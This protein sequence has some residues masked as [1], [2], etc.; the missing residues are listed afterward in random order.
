MKNSC[1]FF[2]FLFA[3]LACQ[4]ITEGDKTT[5]A[6]KQQSANINGIAYNIDTSTSKITWIG[7]KV[8][9]RHTGSIRLIQGV[10]GV[11]NGKVNGGNFIID[12]ASL[13]NEDL[14]AKEKA[15]IEHHLKSADFFDVENHPTASFEISKTDK[16]DSTTTTSVLPG[17]THII[18]GNLTLKGV[19]KNVTFPAKIIIDDKN[20]TV[21]ADFNINRTDWGMN[22]RGANNPQDWLINKNVNLKLTINASQ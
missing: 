19:T 15:K 5:S 13:I 9:G 7:T 8:N 21:K 11:S 4:Q 10:V 6:E 2:L 14:P 20:L 16:F 18:S 1:F 3:A 17:A 22:Y 12:I